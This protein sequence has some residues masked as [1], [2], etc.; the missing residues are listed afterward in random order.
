M[1]HNIQF[2]PGVILSYDTQ[3]F[4]PTAPIL[5][6]PERKWMKQHNRGEI[7]LGGVSEHAR[8]TEDLTNRG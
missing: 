6:V 7:R 5:M 2:S 4:I 3:S 1:A 8:V